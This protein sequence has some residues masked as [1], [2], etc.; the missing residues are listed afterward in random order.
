MSQEEFSKKIGIPFRSYQRYEAGERLPRGR[1][2]SK[3][4][5]QTLVT[6]EWILTGDRKSIEHGENKA[7]RFLATG[8]FL[9]EEVIKAI[10]SPHKKLSLQ[11]IAEILDVD[12]DNPLN[13]LTHPT[14]FYLAIMEL[15]RIFGEGDPDKIG[16]ILAQF[17]AFTPKLTVDKFKEDS[18][19]KGNRER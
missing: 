18:R 17:K 10:R 9:M 19:A 6:P 7:I 3:I 5:E 14:G 11:I 13:R 4:A 15:V 16:A 1:V 12:P 2:L 8:Y